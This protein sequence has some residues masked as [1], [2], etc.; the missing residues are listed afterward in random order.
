MLWIN[1][2]TDWL[3]S[4]SVYKVLNACLIRQFI[5]HRKIWSITLRQFFPSVVISGVRVKLIEERVVRSVVATRKILFHVLLW[6][7]SK[8]NFASKHTKGREKESQVNQQTAR[9]SRRWTSE[10][11]N[12]RIVPRDLFSYRASGYDIDY[13]PQL[14]GISQPLPPGLEEV[15]CRMY[16]ART[17]RRLLNV[18][19]H[20]APRDAL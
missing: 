12:Y 1:F 11:V 13:I 18:H 20:D 7:A 5:R 19:L 6:R 10:G 17:T 15:N 14:V 4:S 2:S 16:D 3:L 8:I 9:E